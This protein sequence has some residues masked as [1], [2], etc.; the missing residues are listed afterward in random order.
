M[1]GMS[2]LEQAVSEMSKS[3]DEAYVNYHNSKGHRYVDDPETK[4][5]RRWDRDYQ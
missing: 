4:M 2:F 5:M 1:D 3:E